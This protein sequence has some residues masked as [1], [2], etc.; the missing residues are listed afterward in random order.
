[1]DSLLLSHNG[2][3]QR[4][5]SF[6][7][8]RLHCFPSAVLF[9]FQLAMY[10]KGNGSALRPAL[11][12]IIFFILAIGVLCFSLKTNDAVISAC[13]YWTFYISTF[14]K[15]LLKDL[16]IFQIG[17]SVF[18]LN[19]KIP[20]FFMAASPLLDEY[21]RYFPQLADLECLFSIFFFGC[22]H[23]MRSSWARD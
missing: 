9:V 4:Y 19:F 5:T 10:E 12:T 17:F 7:R 1:M 6:D 11:G 8:K 16:L 2:N 14:M 15:C 20:F 21:I 3:V 22:I 23:A 13:A 18:L